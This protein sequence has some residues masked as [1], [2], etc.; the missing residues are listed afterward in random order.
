MR[1]KIRN[2]KL[3]KLM[4]SFQTGL[5]TGLVMWVVA[6]LWHNLIVPSFYAKETGANHEGICLMLLSYMILALFMTYLYPFYCRGRSTLLIGFRFGMIIGVLWV[7]PHELL[8][9]GAHGDS[10]SYVFKNGAWHAI[11]Q[12][13]GG[14]VLGLIHAR[15]IGE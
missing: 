3:L 15:K 2:T 6:G 14:V 11:E 9:A 4:K 12:G 5:I 7:F 1:L 10:L 8:M 13:I